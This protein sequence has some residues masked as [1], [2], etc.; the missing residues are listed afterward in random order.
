MAEDGNGDFPIEETG[1]NLLGQITGLSIPPNVE[2]GLW[3]AVGK[4]VTGV[5][6][7]ATAK[8]EATAE[9]IHTEGRA[10]DLVTMAA[11]RAAAEQVPNDPEIVKRALRR[12]GGKLV[13]QQRNVERIAELTVEE[14]KAADPIADPPEPISDRWLDYYSELA[15]RQSNEEM[16]LYFAKILAGEIIRPGQFDP[17][18]L[19]ILNQMT[20][21][22]AKD[23]Q[24]LCSMSVLVED[25]AYVIIF[26]ASLKGPTTTPNPLSDE[27]IKGE[28]LHA[29]GLVLI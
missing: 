6:G 5:V 11:A 13:T 7:L 22:L 21:A 28:Q 19:T 12:F 20:Q 16:Q 3:K 9:S 23:F 29:F 17:T 10:R 18:S 26:V 1:T 14:I 15:E 25:E 2:K 8:L 24:K 4:L 27:G